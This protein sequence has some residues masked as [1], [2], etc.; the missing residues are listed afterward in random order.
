MTTGRDREL[1]AL[2]NEIRDRGT[3]YAALDCYALAAADLETYLARKPRSPQAE[4]LK[5]KVAVLRHKAALVN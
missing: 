1:G 4:E 5:A 3:I 2:A